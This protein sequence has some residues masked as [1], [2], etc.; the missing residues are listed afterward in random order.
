M[1]ISS[2]ATK[3]RSGVT[4]SPRWSGSSGWRPAGQPARAAPHFTQGTGRILWPY[5]SVEGRGA[6][7]A[8]VRGAGAA[9]LRRGQAQDDR[10]VA[11][12]RL[13]PDFGYRVRVR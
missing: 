13:A 8:R 2:P 11:G 10:D 4:T 9:A 6:G 3:T 7:G 5:G 1:P 12:R